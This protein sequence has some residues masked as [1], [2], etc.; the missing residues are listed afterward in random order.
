MLEP[1]DLSPGG[2]SLP[3]LSLPSEDLLLSK[4]LLHFEVSRRSTVSV[5]VTGKE[6]MEGTIDLWDKAEM[7]VCVKLYGTL[8][9]GFRGYRHDQGMELEIPDGATAGDL[10]SLLKISE[11]QRPLVIVEGRILGGEDKLQDSVH[12]NIFQSMQGG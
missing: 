12:V 6:E 4:Y 11:S 1:A 2:I 7:K 5:L 3:F 9:R 8:P 10:L